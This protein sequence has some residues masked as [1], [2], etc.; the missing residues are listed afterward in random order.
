VERREE[1]TKVLQKKINNKSEDAIKL[2]FENGIIGLRLQFYLKNQW[3]KPLRKLEQTSSQVCSS[4]RNFNGEK[5]MIQK[6]DKD[7][8][9]TFQNN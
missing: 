8:D 2:M 6:A 7:R 3:K 4:F 9:E 5:L 1:F